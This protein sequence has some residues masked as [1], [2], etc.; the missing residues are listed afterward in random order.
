MD[1]VIDGLSELDKVI[2]LSMLSAFDVIVQVGISA[3][4]A[5]ALGN[6]A[7][8]AV[9]G[10]KTFAENGLDA[11]S[12]FGSWIGPTC[13]IPNFSFDLLGMFAGLVAAPD[14]VGT[15]NGCS[16][17]NKAQCAKPEPKSDPPPKF[18]PPKV[19][20]PPAKGTEPGPPKDNPLPPT[21][22]PK[23]DPQ[24]PNPPEVVKP[25]P[26]PLPVVGAPKPDI[27]KI[28]P[29]PDTPPINPPK[30][31]E[32]PKADPPS[33]PKPNDPNSPNKP[34]IPATGPDTLQR[35]TPPTPTSHDNTRSGTS[36]CDVKAKRADSNGLVATGFGKDMI[37]RECGT[38][39]ITRTAGTIG[40]YE[41]E[42][43]M[44]CPK[45]Y[46]QACYHYR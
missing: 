3:V 4:P 19:G 35:T 2:C 12:F 26:N 9:Q 22:P 8:A 40:S 44:K 30:I 5:G 23:A 20:P 17:K 46:S 7:R 45:K 25:P 36:A 41:K 28:D 32:P 43:P 6:A 18:H 24:V 15:S 42:I 29:L 34:T 1:V 21:T 31:F 38:L 10:A 33:Q 39:H 27:P 37:N 13:G 16:R 11:A 14:S